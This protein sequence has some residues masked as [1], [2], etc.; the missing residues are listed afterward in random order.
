MAIFI[1]V[2]F[3]FVYSFRGSGIENCLRRYGRGAKVYLRKMEFPIPKSLIFKVFPTYLT[4]NPLEWTF[5]VAPFNFSS[6][7]LETSGIIYASLFNP[8]YT[9]SP[10]VANLHPLG[11]PF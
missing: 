3:G 4:F 5:F 6:H 10:M 8:S 11:V 2:I 9:Q 7:K 1:R